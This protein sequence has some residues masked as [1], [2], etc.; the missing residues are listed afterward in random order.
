MPYK[1]RDPVPE[2]EMNIIDYE[3][4][5]SICQFLRDIYHMETNEEIKIKLRI[6]MAMAKAM[7]SKIQYYKHKEQGI[8]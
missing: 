3:G 4:H 2:K 6:T 7:N 5:H 8:I 1:H